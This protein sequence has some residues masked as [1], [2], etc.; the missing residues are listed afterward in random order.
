MCFMGTFSGI[1]NLES[2][3]WCQRVLKKLSINT[4]I[5]KSFLGASIT[6][7]LK[8]VRKSVMIWNVDIKMP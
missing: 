2:F 5:Q 7:K 1:L 6:R 8:P 4:K 3:M